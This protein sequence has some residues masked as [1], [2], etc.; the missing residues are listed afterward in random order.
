MSTGNSNTTSLLVREPYT[1][2]KVSSLVS[3]FTISLGSKRI[4]KVLEPSSLYLIRLPTISVGY[5]ISSR[6]AS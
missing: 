4:F 6:I 2:A 5:T 3:M 1:L